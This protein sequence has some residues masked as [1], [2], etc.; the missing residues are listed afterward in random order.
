MRIFISLEMRP[1]YGRTFNYVYNRLSSL[2][3]GA[4]ELLVKVDNEN[5]KLLTLIAIMNTDKLF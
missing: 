2:P 3:D 5:A 1:D 4:V